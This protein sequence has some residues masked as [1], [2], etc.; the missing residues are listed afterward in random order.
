MTNTDDTT[1]EW[2]KKAV[3]LLER[4]ALDGLPADEDAKR[5]RFE[6]FLRALPPLRREDFEKAGDGPANFLQQVA[7]D[8]PP[9]SPYYVGS[10][11]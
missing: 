6:A 1:T 5:G 9:A 2:M 11:E 4:G 3:E 10:E 7:D 8:D